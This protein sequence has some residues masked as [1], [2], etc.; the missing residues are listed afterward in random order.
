MLE[1][2]HWI[3]ILHGMQTLMNQ[4]ATTTGACWAA[5]VVAAATNS[6]S[7]CVALTFFVTTK[8]PSNGSPLNVVIPVLILIFELTLNP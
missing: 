1:Y 5:S 6:H 7:N 2:H 4:H 3:Q 8:L